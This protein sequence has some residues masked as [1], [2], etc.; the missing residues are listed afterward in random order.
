MLVLKGT[1]LSDTLIQLEQHRP[2][3]S[4]RTYFDA[5]NHFLSIDK[6]LPSDITPY[7]VLESHNGQLFAI[8]QINCGYGGAGPHRTEQVLEWLGIPHELAEQ[9][10]YHSGIKVEFD[11][12]GNWLPETVEFRVVFESRAER[13][14][15]ILLGGNVFSSQAQRTIYFLDPQKDKMRYLYH[16]FRRCDAKEATF[17]VGDSASNHMP[18]ASI[19]GSRIFTDRDYHGIER[20]GF[21]RVQGERF[22]VICLIG[23]E[24]ICSFIQNIHIH[25]FGRGL[26]HENRIAGCIVFS[27]R[28]MENTL[29]NR[30]IL[31]LKALVNTSAP[32]IY[33]TKEIPPRHR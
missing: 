11:T 9:W 26:L 3:R 15:E 12:D 20:G 29:K 4:F 19:L 24:S 6:Q 28:Q 7:A 23:R 22:N 32:E 30:M 5:E 10:I 33:I 2:F 18:Y 17:Y 13:D 25:F 16:A 21:V 8:S 27:I 31:L 14:P 1:H